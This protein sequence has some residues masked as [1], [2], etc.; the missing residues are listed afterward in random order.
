MLAVAS[1]L[2]KKGAKI[3]VIAEQAPIGRLARFALGL[4]SEPAKLRQ[5]IELRAS[6][7]LRRVSPGMVAGRG[8]GRRSMG[9]ERSVTLTE[10]SQGR[11]DYVCD[12]L[13]CG[14]GLI[15]NLE[16]ASLLGCQARSRRHGG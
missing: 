7:G 3:A 15:P 9:F 16:L 2:A 1:A 4:W 11:F 5:A 8:F 10:R 14:F 6:L 12:Y 13:A